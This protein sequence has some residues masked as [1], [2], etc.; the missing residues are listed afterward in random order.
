MGILIYFLAIFFWQTYV[1][2]RHTHQTM[3]CACSNDSQ[4]AYTQFEIVDHGLYY[5]E[6]KEERY[7]GVRDASKMTPLR[8]IGTRLVTHPTSWDHPKA[9]DASKWYLLIIATGGGSD[10][11][12]SAERKILLQVETSEEHNSLTYR[13]KS[14]IEMVDIEAPFKMELDAFLSRLSSYGKDS[15]AYYKF[16]IALTS[17][18][19]FS[20]ART[21][22][23]K[24]IELDYRICRRNFKEYKL[25][26]EIVETVLEDDPSFAP[27][28]QYY[29]FRLLKRGEI[30][31]ARSFAEE[32]IR[33]DPMYA[34]A[35]Y[36][37]GMCLWSKKTSGGDLSEARQ[38]L[39]EAIRLNPEYALA[40]IGYGAV[41]TKLK[42]FSAARSA[43]EKAIKLNP[44]NA[45]AYFN[46]GNLF[47]EGFGD[48][49]AACRAYEKAIEIY[50]KYAAAYLTYS[51]AL[52]RLAMDSEANIAYEKAIQLDP[53]LSAAQDASLLTPRVS[54]RHWSP[55]NNLVDFERNHR[56][57]DGMS[58]LSPRTSPRN[59]SPRNFQ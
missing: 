29:S 16:G 49:T 24:A 1:E 57:S 34:H 44:G 27:A 26:Q 31:M 18:K 7:A 28:L 11:W 47:M 56:E 45:T 40:Y 3:G 50:P 21:L 30:D 32:A 2:H 37:L 59:W 5:Y 53:S 54:P 58:L 22:Y 13:L 42:D 19:A 41:M 6:S 9:S 33:I 35:H 20:A 14:S 43:Y 15:A 46:Y 36:I 48:F 25:P 10:F 12:H 52:R 23:L 55:R 51:V 38:A 17:L 39:E 8:R 4:P